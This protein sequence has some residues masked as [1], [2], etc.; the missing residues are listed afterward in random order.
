VE[1]GEG[2]RSCQENDAILDFLL[3][4]RP[5]V[6]WIS[7]RVN[8]SASQRFLRFGGGESGEI[9]KTDHTE[10]LTPDRRIVSSVR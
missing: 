1:I 6:S 9:L 7:S 2:S 4:S 5:V 10:I 3:L 8:A